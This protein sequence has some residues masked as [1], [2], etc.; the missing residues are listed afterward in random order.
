[1]GDGDGMEHVGKTNDRSKAIS[2]RGPPIHLAMSEATRGVNCA[3]ERRHTYSAMEGIAI[4]IVPACTTT[5]FGQ[6]TSS[7]SESR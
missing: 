5:H 7:R 1:M 2:R 4:G 3:R 6:D